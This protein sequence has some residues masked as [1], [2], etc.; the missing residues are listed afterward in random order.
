MSWCVKLAN[1]GSILI[2]SFA[3]GAYVPERKDRRVG[4]SC[5]GPDGEWF[6]EN[7]YDLTWAQAIAFVHGA[8]AASGT[9]QPR[10]VPFRG[11]Q[12]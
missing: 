7:S 11:I 1:G 12:C 10:P 3:D 2:G 9:E 5:Y 4:V 8:K 6:D